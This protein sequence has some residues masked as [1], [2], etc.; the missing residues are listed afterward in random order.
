MEFRRILLPTDLSEEGER[1]FPALAELARRYGTSI[2]LLHVVEDIAVAP[3]GEA[4]A[5]VPPVVIPGVPQEMKRVRA[6]LE[7]RKKKLGSNI[8]VAV[9]VIAAASVPRAIAQ[10]ALEKGCDL[11]ALSTHGRS[12][13]RRM[14]MGSVAEAVLRHAKVPVLIFPRA[15]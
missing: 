9:D 3:A 1:A 6:V 7:E 4:A 10:H 12:G 11:I 15:E 14:I 8:D 13:F 2:L 5:A